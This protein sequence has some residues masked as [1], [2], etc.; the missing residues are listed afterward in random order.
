MRSMGCGLLQALHGCAEAWDVVCYRACMDV[1]KHVCY[2]VLVPQ[3]LTDSV[4]V[5]LTRLCRSMLRS[6]QQ[7]L[8]SS[9]SSSSRYPQL[10]SSTIRSKATSTTSS[11]SSRQAAR[12]G[13]QKGE[14]QGTR[15]QQQQGKVEEKVQ[16][17]PWCW[18]YQRT[19]SS[20]HSS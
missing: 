3:Q 4:T 14:K 13:H 15:Q 8:G 11:S 6:I 19:W 5:P 12:H 1:Q 10:I 7:L 9:G 18:I 16:K 20:C 17:M 2:A